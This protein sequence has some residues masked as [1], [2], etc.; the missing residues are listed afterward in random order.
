MLW[1]LGLAAW[2]AI[3]WSHRIDD[4]RR[5]Y[6]QAKQHARAFGMP[7][8]VI[9]APDRGATKGPG[10]GDLTIDITPSSCPRS[11]QMDITKP[12]PIA[13]NSAVIFVSCVLEYVDDVNAA[14]NE[15]QRIAPERVYVCRVQ[16]W[17]LAAYA[18]PG[19]KR[20]LSTSFCRMR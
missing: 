4:R 10:C 18:Y 14:W 7:L 6:W 9:G 8:I 13:S 20:T 17:T 15:L 11:M 5:L 16:P 2:E 12:M 3:W 1:L 19:A